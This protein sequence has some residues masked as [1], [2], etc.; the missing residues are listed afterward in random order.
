MIRAWRNGGAPLG[1]IKRTDWVGAITLSIDFSCCVT[2]VG[3]ICEWNP[4]CLCSSGERGELR[5]SGRPQPMCVFPFKIHAREMNLRRLVSHIYI[6]ENSQKRIYRSKLK[7]GS[8]LGDGGV[9]WGGVWGREKDPLIWMWMKWHPLL[10]FVFHTHTHT[11][12][13][14]TCDLCVWDLCVTVSSHSCI[15]CEIHPDSVLYSLCV[16]LMC[17]LYNSYWS[18]FLQSFPK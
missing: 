6:V 16:C 5:A 3:E 18:G 12:A 2:E 7:G 13:W 8:L 15:V 17:G 4:F 14:E 9:G 11:Q 10:I 1:A